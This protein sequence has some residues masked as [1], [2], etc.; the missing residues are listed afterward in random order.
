MAWGEGIAVTLPDLAEKFNRCKLLVMVE[1]ADAPDRPPG[2]RESK[3]ART[4]QA[5]SDVATR[6]FAEHGFEQVTVAQIAA[7]A[8]V[9]VKTVFNY[10]GSKEELFFDRADEL[11]AGL[12]RTVTDRPPGVTVTDALHALL[13]ENLVPFPGAAWHPLRDA[14]AYEHFRAFVATEDASPA[15]RA[16]R[17]ILAAGWAAPL[18]AA[19]AA[20]FGIDADDAR[21]EAYA[22]MLLAIMGLRQRML[23]AAVLERLSA[24]TVERRVRAAMDEAFER[25]ARA[26]ADVDRPAA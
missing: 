18:T 26:F 15:L 16:R 9:S 8:D 3:K 21:A 7:A 20:A 1:M 2:L 19:I 4:R 6:L 12:V 5:I 11:L 10:F 14:E 17:L 23:S 22:G 25:L 13:T 24:R